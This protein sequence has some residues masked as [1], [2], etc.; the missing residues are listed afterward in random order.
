MWLDPLS[1]GRGVQTLQQFSDNRSPNRL[2]VHGLSQDLHRQDVVVS[3]DDQSRQEIR[4]AEHHT[5]GVGVAD[6]A[7]AIFDRLLNSLAHQSREVLHGG[8]RD[9]PDRNLRAAG[10]KRRSQKSSKL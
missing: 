6:K 9:H 8:M 3:V 7:L 2:A 10:I 4:F 5:V 1:D